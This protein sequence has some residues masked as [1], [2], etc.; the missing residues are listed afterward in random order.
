MSDGTASRAYVDQQI[1]AA[2]RAIC[3]RVLPMIAKQQKDTEL[4]SLRLDTEANAIDARFRMVN[5]AAKPRH[6]VKAP[7]RAMP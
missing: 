7:S 3:D 1:D 4:L 6:R 2:F 5:T